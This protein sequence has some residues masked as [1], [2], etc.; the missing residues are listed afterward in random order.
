MKEGI[1]KQ[2]SS[3]ETSPKNLENPVY[4]KPISSIE[5]EQG[6]ELVETLEDDFKD[7]FRAR[8]Y[9]EHEPVLISSGIDPTVR[10]IGSHISVFKPYLLSETVPT[11]GYFMTQDCIRTQNVKRL[12]DDEYLPH[13]GSFFTSLGTISPSDRLNDVCGE[14][15]SFLKE[16][17]DINANDI[18]VRVSS[19]DIDLHETSKKVFHEDNLEVDTQRETY[20]RHKIG[21]DGVWGR[22]FN[23]ALRNANGEG[24]SD[25]GNII[26]IENNEKK[27]GVELALG[28]TTILKQIYNIEHVNDFYPVIGLPKLDP[29]ISRKLEDSIIVSTTLLREGLEP[30]ASD[31]R[32]RILRTYIRSILYFKERTGLSMDTIEDVLKRFEQE[33]FGANDSSASNK[34][35]EYLR[36]YEQGLVSSGAK[37]PEDEVILS[38]LH[39]N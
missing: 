5:R 29:R 28:A 19:K 18:R 32:G 34:I 30:N 23:I 3:A 9:E 14:S 11:P 31:N 13:W 4:Q 7:F 20:Y 24:F 36:E 35:T 1:P 15:L 27:L 12:F 25:V 37:T 39:K 2:P 6:P 21:I 8:G 38:A 26:L 16:K 22:N 33:Q 17:L 10:F